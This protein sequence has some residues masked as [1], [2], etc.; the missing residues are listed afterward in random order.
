MRIVSALDHRYKYFRFREDAVGKPGHTPIQKCTAAIRQLVY[1]G[2]TDMFDEYLH[3]GE[4]TARDCLKYFCEGV[5]EIF[6]EW[7]LRK[8]SPVDCQQISR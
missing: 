4:S 1:G 3:V 8:P 2:T 6:G 5:R 7:Y